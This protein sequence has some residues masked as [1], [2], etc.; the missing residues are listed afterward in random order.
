MKVAVAILLTSSIALTAAIFQSPKATSLHSASPMAA[1]AQQLTP[2][3]LAIIARIIACPAL[4]SNAVPTDT[5]V[6]NLIRVLASGCPSTAQPRGTNRVVTWQCD[7]GKGV[8]EIIGKTNLA[9]SNWL[10][11]AYIVPTNGTVAWTNSGGCRFFR[12][13]YLLPR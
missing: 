13:R 10:G 4:G 5:S 9:D 3:Q 11:C 2:L 8:Y 1:T 7:S 12:L 6:T